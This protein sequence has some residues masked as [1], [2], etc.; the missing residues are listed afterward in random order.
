VSVRAKKKRTRKPKLKLVSLHARD[1]EALAGLLNATAIEI[2]ES[3][4][5]VTG[6]IVITTVAEGQVGAAYCSANEVELVGALEA[7]KKRI[8]AEW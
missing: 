8:M 2:A 3:R 7:L 4:A 5:R 1:N 6:Y